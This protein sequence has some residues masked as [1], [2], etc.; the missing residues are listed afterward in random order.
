MK[1][2]IKSKSLD[3]V[4][5]FIGSILALF[6]SNKVMTNIQAFFNTLKIST[7]TQR[8]LSTIIFALFVAIGYISVLIIF[9]I[10]S[11]ILAYFFRPLIKINFK[12]EKGKPITFL[13]ITSDE[14]EY[15]NIEVNSKFNRL[16]LWIICELLKAKLVILVNP[17]MCSIELAE[18]YI[19]TDSIY[20]MDKSNGTI[21]C[22]IFTMYSSSKKY[23][24]IDIELNILRTLRAD[25]EFKIKL[26]I[27]DCKLAKLIFLEEYCK[28]KIEEFRIEGRG[29]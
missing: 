23:K 6:F 21:H 20:S 15:V 26:D 8:T 3:A 28:F 1:E 4:A 18:G 17:R 24:P 7:E 5:T 14:P 2:K 12:N 19:A 29:N 11:S 27:T 9:K 25:A 16:Q 22:N 13:D 10:I